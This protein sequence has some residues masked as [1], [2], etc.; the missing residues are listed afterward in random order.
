MLYIRA[1]EITHL[2]Y[3]KIYT[4]KQTL[5]LFLSPLSLAVTI[6]LAAALNW[7]ILVATY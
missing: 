3:L 5:P 1:V 7:I 2:V 4:Q 6:L